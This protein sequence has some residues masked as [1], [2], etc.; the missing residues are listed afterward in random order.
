M[1]MTDRERFNAC[2]HFESVDHVPDEEFGYWEEVFPIWHEQGLPEWV[3]DNGK[4]DQYFGFATK[5]G[6]PG[7]IGI[8]PGYKTRVIE[9]DDRRILLEDGDGALKEVAKDGHSTIPRYLRFPIETKDD[10]KRFRDERFDSSNPDRRDIDWDSVIKQ[11]EGHDY[12]LGLNC[13][14]L[15]GWIRNWMGFENVSIACVEDPDWIEEMM[16]A[17]TDMVL[18]MLDDTISHAG[19]LGLDYASFWEDMAFNHGPII[20]PAMFERWLT[21]RYKKITDRLREAG[22]DVCIV[23]CDGNINV[24]VEH[25]LAGGV[26]VMFPLE[27]RGGTDPVTIREKYG[28]DVLLAGGVDKTQLIEGK[29]AIRKELNRIESTIADGGFIPHV[30]HR[31]PPDVTYDDYLYYVKTKREML[32]IPEPVSYEDRKA[33]GLV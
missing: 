29:E 25:W 32:G 26:N 15:F 20:S 19:H 30:D 8:M 18:T 2:M 31:C 10:W 13:G 6:L 17:I 33:A 14:S 24:V 28:H 11:H 23:D 7:N 27:I 16:D 1:S 4:A 12:P 5:G 21:P 9:E 3:T 22:V